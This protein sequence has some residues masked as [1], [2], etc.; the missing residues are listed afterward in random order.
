P[1]AKLA[2]VKSIERWPVPNESQPLHTIEAGRSVGITLD[3]ELFLERGHIL[4]L[5]A[6]P[7]ADSRNIRARVF[8]LHQK[9]LI[10]GSPVVVRLGTAEVR[11]EVTA[12][13]RT[14]DPGRLEAG[15]EQSIPQN[16]VGEVCIELA[17]P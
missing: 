6:T 15:T 14:I 8:W 10:A 13:I 17:K 1:G 12:I 5:A 11:G 2:L 7:I 16:H 4:S 9:P 3:R